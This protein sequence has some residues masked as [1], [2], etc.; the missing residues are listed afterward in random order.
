M[1]TLGAW[2]NSAVTVPV[3]T[4]S[5]L[6]SELLF[7]GLVLQEKKNKENSTNKIPVENKLSFFEVSNISLDLGLKIFSDIIFKNEL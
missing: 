2:V 4:V 7:P 3:I 5:I 1:G 6:F